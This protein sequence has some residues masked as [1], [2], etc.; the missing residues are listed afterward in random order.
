MVAVSV[1]GADLMDV[2]SPEML[3]EYEG[4]VPKDVVTSALNNIQMY[5]P[6]VHT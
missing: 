5:Q 4:T 3:E 2:F 6:H 1:Y